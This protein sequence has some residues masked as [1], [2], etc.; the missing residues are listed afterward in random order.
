MTGEDYDGDG[1]SDAY[2][3]MDKQLEYINSLALS[4]SQKR[5]LAIA[6]G[7]KEKS[8]DKRAPW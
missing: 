6:C 2:S 5:A 7:I 3:K 8:V 1:E 4:A